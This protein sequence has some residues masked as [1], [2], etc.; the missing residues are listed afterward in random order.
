[1]ELRVEDRCGFSLELFENCKVSNFIS[2]LKLGF[3]YLEYV[4]FLPTEHRGSSSRPRH[5][6]SRPKLC[7]CAIVDVGPRSVASRIRQ[8]SHQ[9]VTRFF[10]LVLM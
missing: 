10:L 9:R 6:P 4:L 5:G 3:Q 8:I 7:T 2:P 1:M